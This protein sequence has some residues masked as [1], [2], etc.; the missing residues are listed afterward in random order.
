MIDL[1]NTTFIIPIRIESDDRLRNIITVCCY[2]LSVF[3]TNV[4]VKEVDNESVFES[5]A[6]PQIS[7]YLDNNL[8]N[9]TH[10]FE[11][12]NPDDHVFY[13]MRYLNE[14]LSMTDTEVVVNYDGD[15]LLEPETCVTARDMIVNENFDVVYPYGWGDYQKMVFAD[16]QMV[17]NFLSN[18]CDF[19]QFDR[20]NINRSESGHVQFFKRQSYIE[21]GMENENFKGSSP[22]DKERLNRFNVLGYNVGR[23]N[24][25]VYHL[26]HSR[27]NNSWPNS[28]RGNPFMQDN[29]L[30]WD[31]LEKLDKEQLKE[32]YSNQSY[33]QK[34]SK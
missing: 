10:I 13:R 15:V 25:Y 32:Y 27:G 30:L 9:L 34:Y 3:D 26:E 29:L 2:L 22:D 14:M 20:V 7:E 33:L 17:S 28:Y 11:K 21:G 18:D 5:H 19:S 24:D 12:S 1:K 8:D 31:K 4:I 16:D 6:L 23:I